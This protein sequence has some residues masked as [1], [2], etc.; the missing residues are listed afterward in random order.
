MAHRWLTAALVLSAVSYIASS[1]QFSFNPSAI[2]VE[3]AV[4]R[5]GSPSAYLCRTPCRP[6]HMLCAVTAV[7][8]IQ[9]VV[10]KQQR[11]RRLLADC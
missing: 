2:D 8:V 10:S 7:D 1:L 4:V 6:T 11:N 5:S 3:G 9:P